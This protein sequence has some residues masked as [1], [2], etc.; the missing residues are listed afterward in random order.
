MKVGLIVPGFSSDATDWGVPVL[1]DV[2]REMSQRV[3]LHVFAL[4]YPHRNDRYHLHGTE[5]HALGGGT[6]RG[7]RRPAL[8]ARACAGVIGEH[9]RRPF[10]AL[11]G[12]W[13]D[14]PGFV[15]V[16]AGRL[17][18][19]PAIVSIMGGEL[20]S[21][22][23]IGYGGHLAWSN[24]LLSAIALHGAA[25]VTAGSSQLAE[26]AR[27]SLRPSRRSR[28]T[29]LVWGIDP[30]LFELRGQSLELA[31]EVRVL[32]VGSLVPIKD[33]VTLLRAIARIRESEAGIHLHIVGDGPLRGQLPDQARTL[34][35]TTCVTFH[36]H[37]DRRGLAAYYRAAH[38][39]AVTSRYEAQLVVALEAA[40]CGTPIVGTAVGLVADLA[41][42]GATAV[43]VGDDGAL[44]EAICAAAR[45]DTGAALA[46]AAGRLVESDH[47]AAH[48][49]DRLTSI[50][51]HAAMAETP[52]PCR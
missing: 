49:A 20:V 8:L 48:T 31:G 51:R 47:L 30:C 23:N 25:R 26:C 27:R 36:G 24:R 5:V 13:A 44:A 6:V 3:E 18:H 19:I 43:P 45:A 15:A 39:L 46:T 12:I 9:R 41:P 34:G 33:Q 37:V 38:V 1:V 35:L 40:V 52:L 32:H 29:R 14:E 16:A 11:H 7:L 50:Y 21:M 10:A 42:Q 28:V 22:P 4:R 17:L 2:I